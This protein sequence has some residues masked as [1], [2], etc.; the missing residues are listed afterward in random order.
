MRLYFKSPSPGLS[1]KDEVIP[2]LAGDTGDMGR[3]HDIQ[4]RP[5]LFKLFN[6]PWT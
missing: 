5:E 1:I 2:A 6:R 4:P 3:N